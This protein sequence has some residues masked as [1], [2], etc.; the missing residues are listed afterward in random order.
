MDLYTLIKMIKE[1]R[2]YDEVAKEL[3][4][5]ASSLRRQIN[6]I[7]AYIEG[8]KAQARSGRRRGEE[9]AE[10]MRRA[11]EK[12]TGRPVKTGERGARRKLKFQSLK[13]ALRY[14]EPIAHISRLKKRKEEEEWE[15]EIDDD[16][17]LG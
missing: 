17:M 11:I 12:A 13:D 2:L 6:R 16:S 8:R 9:Y 1:L 14:S 5:K 10:A 7:E 15:L 4:I 3:G